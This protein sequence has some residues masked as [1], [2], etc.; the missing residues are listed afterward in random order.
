MKCGIDQ[1]L[2]VKAEE[3]AA[4]VDVI[5][6]VA[7]LKGHPHLRDKD[8]ASATEET[9]A[10]KKMAHRQVVMEIDGNQ[11]N[12]KGGVKLECDDTCLC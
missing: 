5:V 6:V 8:T 1:G 11:P 3:A 7:I 4:V 10:L 9:L 2:A 12:H